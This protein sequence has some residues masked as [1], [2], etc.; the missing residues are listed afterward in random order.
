DKST[1]QIRDYNDKHECGEIYHVKNYNSTWIEKK[2][3]EMSRTDPKRSVKGFRH[4]VIIDIRCHVS[5]SQ[6]YRAKW[7]ALKKIEGLSV[8]Q[9]GRLWDYVEEL[10]GSNPSSTFIL[11][12]A[13]SDGSAGSKFGKLYVCFE[14]LKLA[15]FASCRRS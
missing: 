4:D 12:R 5:K 14:G 11:S 1:F 13:A 9:Y 6:A 3:E 7:N 10:R 2:Y 8:D 15:F